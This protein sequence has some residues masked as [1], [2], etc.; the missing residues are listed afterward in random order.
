MADLSGMA[1]Y[2][3]N[4]LCC[5]WGTRIGTEDHGQVCHNRAVQMVALH[6]EHGHTHEVKLC[7]PHLKFVNMESTPSEVSHGS[8]TA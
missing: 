4:L 1:G 6:N 2:V 7:L 8:E 5:D 3:H